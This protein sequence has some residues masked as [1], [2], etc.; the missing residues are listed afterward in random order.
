MFQS[1]YN[2]FSTFTISNW[3]ELLGI[4]ASLSTSIIAIFISIKTLK[5]NNQMIEESTRPIIHIYSKYTDGIVYIIIRNIGQ[6]VAYIDNIDT[7][8]S[9]DHKNMVSG[10]PF[11][12]LK[13]AS[14]PPQT[15]RICPLI[16][17][18]LKEK[19]FTFNINYH[20]LSNSYEDNIIVD[21]EAE[22]PF[23]SNHTG[24]KNDDEFAALKVIAH[25]LQDI[26]KTK[27]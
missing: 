9:I 11:P 4:M 1:I 25:T 17:H 18:T 12:L 8:F 22:N 14:I 27:L 19:K 21:I 5:Q 13:N 3:L 10:N 7:D 16:A 24:I 15:S 23:P 26:L 2:F 20:S 6:S